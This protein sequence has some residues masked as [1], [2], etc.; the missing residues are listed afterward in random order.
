MR[1]PQGA[2]SPERSGFA[3]VE[4]VMVLVVLGIIA[5]FAL[6]RIDLNKYRVESAAQSIGSTFL[7]AQ[8]LAITRQHDVRVVFDVAGAAFSIHEDTDNDGVVAGAERNLR[9]PLGEHVVFGL[10]GAPAAAMGPGP[11]TFTKTSGG[12]PVLVFHRNGAASEAGGFYI[13]T[14]RAVNASGYPQDARAIEIDRATGRAS[15][16]RYING[17]WRRVF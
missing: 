14:D 5:L 6:P 1:K 12:S 8:R 9:H 17:G 3:L 10:G 16:S 15:W 2:R 11:L 4:L 13:T 7:A